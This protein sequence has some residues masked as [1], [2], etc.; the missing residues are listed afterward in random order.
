[1]VMMLFS[2]MACLMLVILVTIGFIFVVVS[3]SN[4]DTVSEARQG[5]IFR[6]SDKDE[7]GW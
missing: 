5:W 2:T 6:R 3:F 7:H 1:M 4:P